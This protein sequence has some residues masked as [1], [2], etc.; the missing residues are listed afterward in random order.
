[1]MVVQI[2][3]V[4]KF[5]HISKPM[6]MYEYFLHLIVRQSNAHDG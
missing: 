5:Q 2:L 4:M 6:E 1:M 3:I